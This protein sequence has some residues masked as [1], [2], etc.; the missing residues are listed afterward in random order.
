MGK[1]VLETI[2]LKKGVEFIHGNFFN[3]GNIENKDH[4]KMINKMFLI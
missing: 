4:S 3:K 2:V 1:T